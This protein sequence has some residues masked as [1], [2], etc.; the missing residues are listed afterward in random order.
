MET[1]EIYK[2]AADYVRSFNA[3]ER[4]MTK[5]IIGAISKLDAPLKPSAEGNFSFGAYL[6][7]LTD[8][9]IQRDRDEV[10]G[11][12][13]EKIR[14]LAPYV[15]AATMDGIIC[16]IGNENRIEGAKDNFTSVLSVF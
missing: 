15:E 13:N 1:Y 16:A 7:G 4:D 2:G 11:A 10:L 8:E 9:D 12:D 5:Y 14:E 6:M 3:D